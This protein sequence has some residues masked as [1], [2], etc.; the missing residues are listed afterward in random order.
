MISKR[1]HSIALL[2]ILLLAPIA[3][4]QKST[5]EAPASPVTSP[6][7][8]PM[9][10]NDGEAVRALLIRSLLAMETAMQVTDNMQGLAEI[11]NLQLDVQLMDTPT[12]EMLAAGAPPLA[13]LEERLIRA[14][15]E[16]DD[17]LADMQFGHQTRNIEFPEPELTISQCSLINATTTFA[18][19]SVWSIVREVLSVTRWVCIQEIGGFNASESCKVESVLNDAFK[20]I[21]LG[22][23][24]CLEEQRDAYLEALLETQENIADHLSDFVDATSSSR[25][26]QDSVDDVQ[27]TV[28]SNISSLSDLDT[29]LSTDLTSIENDLQNAL[30]ELDELMADA[31]DLISVSSDIQLRVQ[32]NQ[33]DV[34][35][36]QTRAD[37][38]QETAGEIRTDTQS[39]ISSLTDLQTSLDSLQTELTGSLGQASKALLVAALADSDSHIVRFML[40]Q[41][42]G[43]EL[44]AARE[45]VIAAIT[46][47][48]GLGAN[49]NTALSLL[50]DGD[51][52]YNQQDYLTAYRLFAMS[53]QSLTGNGNGIRRTS[54]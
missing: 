14:E 47:Y 4:A 52:A 16:L 10:Q 33:I 22:A 9:Q 38:A 24:A 28:S 7:P 18:A 42:A 13:S 5:A 19:F 27:T 36:A 54:P 37:D 2:L 32:E 25:A 20:F 44:E 30:D 31:N 53:Y 17:A 39:I 15:A 50:A 29:S 11:Q 12:L 48:Q 23:V 46:A 49:T 1:H 35:D 26:S 51:V 43:G 45:I 3:N 8:A 40:P 21:Y 6:T 41:S 34:E